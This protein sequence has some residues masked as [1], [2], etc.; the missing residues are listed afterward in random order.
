LSSHVEV[1]CCTE[2][3]TGGEAGGLTKRG[4][5]LENFKGI[6]KNSGGWHKGKSPRLDVTTCE[7][8]RG[9]PINSNRCEEL[10]TESN[11]GCLRPGT[12]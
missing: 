4:D 8:L 1:I 11:E 5:P 9:T 10:W 7:M 2:K 12:G 3:E 6:G